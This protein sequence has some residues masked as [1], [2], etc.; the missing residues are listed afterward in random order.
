MGAYAFVFCSM[1][2]SIECVLPK[3][4]WNANLYDVADLEQ[5]VIILAFDHGLRKK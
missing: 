5:A 2:A 4:E 1:V 3:G